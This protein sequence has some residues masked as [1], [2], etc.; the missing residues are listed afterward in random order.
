ME[1]QLFLSLC[2]HYKFF[3]HLLTDCTFPSLE[4]LLQ[5]HALIGTYLKT[6]KREVGHLYISEYDLFSLSLCVSLSLPLSPAWYSFLWLVLLYW[7][8]WK[9]NIST[10]FREANSPCPHS[11]SLH[12]SLETLSRCK[13]RCSYT[14]YFICC[15]SP[16]EVSCTACFP[17]LENLCLVSALLQF[18]LF[19]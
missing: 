18:S 19:G 11:S 8:T 15:S 13:L 1:H 5:I 7:P 3:C 9:P 17:I 16:G 10:E 4:Q 2:E 14:S 12:F 6:Y